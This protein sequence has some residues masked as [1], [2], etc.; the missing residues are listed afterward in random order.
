MTP[1][2]TLL[3][4]I[5]WILMIAGGL[6][7]IYRLIKGTANQKIVRYVPPVLEVPTGGFDGQVT[8]LTK[9]I[10]SAEK[11]YHF[12][13]IYVCIAHISRFFH[14]EP[15]VYQTVMDLYKAA[16]DKEMEL[17]LATITNSQTV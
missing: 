8:Y 1:H 14:D 16:W 9:L 7:F 6:L 3:I 5:M 11:D 2:Q 17:F 15:E 12:I 10:L 13:K 4:T